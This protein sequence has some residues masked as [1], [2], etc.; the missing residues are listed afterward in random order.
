MSRGARLARGTLQVL[1]AESL[2][3]PAGIV[4]AAFLARALG[5]HDFGT[6][7]ISTSIVTTIEWVVVAL[8]SRVVVK[9]ISEDRDWRPVASLALRMATMLGLAAG[10][11]IWALA[12]P[13]A[14]LWQQPSLA[15]YLR[16]LAWEVPFV[17]AAYTCRHV[18]TG[19]GRYLQRAATTATYWVSR[20]TLVIVAVLAGWAVEG[21]IVGGVL[22]AVLAFVVGQSYARIPLRS[23]ARVASGR[24][25]RFAMPLFALALCLRLLERIGLLTLTMLGRPA[26][27]AGWYAAA[28]GFAIPT[29]LFSMSLAPLLLSAIGT[30]RRDGDL[31]GARGLV[32]LGYRAIVLLLPFAAIAGGAADELVSLVYGDAFLPAA[33]LAAPILAAALGA[34][35]VSV[36]G[37]AL[38]AVNQMRHVTV[39][40]WLMVPVLL[41]LLWMTVPRYGAP[42]A[43]VTTAI[44]CALAAG[45]IVVRVHAA[46]GVWPGAV[47]IAKSAALAAL[48]WAASAVWP[49]NGG[50]VVAKG[51]ILCGVTIAVLVAAGEVGPREWRLVRE[52]RRPAGALPK[53]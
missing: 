50:W 6:L 4:T 28:H 12:G 48:M 44:A 51:V 49:A 45:P 37:S 1:I 41:V 36:G 33:G 14:D 27:E 47:T 38:A 13:A 29:T 3:V 40:A 21:A 42:A 52:I 5:P 16:L 31:D 34:T 25:W 23:T 7:T 18:L 46:W 35:V 20:P 8:F 53:P 39:L 26:A 30:A 15:N 11:A 9:L 19:R 10:A 43:A 2:V 17:A 24:L 22:A 32:A